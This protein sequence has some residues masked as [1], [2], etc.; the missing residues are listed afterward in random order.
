[1]TIADSE[2]TCRIM[3]SSV[4]AIIIGNN[5]TIARVALPDSSI[6]PAV[7]MR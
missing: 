4:R 5:G 6:D 3:I 7:S 1:M 2:R